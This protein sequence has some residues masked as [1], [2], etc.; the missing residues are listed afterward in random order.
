VGKLNH[1]NKPRRG[2]TNDFP[3]DDRSH[4]DSPFGSFGKTAAVFMETN[5]FRSNYIEVLMRSQK[6]LT[7]GLLLLAGL[8][9]SVPLGAQTRPVVI[10]GG[11]LIDGTGREA[12]TDAAIVL[13]DGR[14]QEVGKRGQVTLP[15][16]AEVINATGKT[17]LPGLIDGHCH[18]WEWVGELY[19][20]YGVTT[21]PDINNSPTEWILAQRD[22]IQKGKIR[23]PRLWI[24]GYALD[25]PRPEGMPEQR[26]M[27]NSIIVRSEEEA[28]QAVRAH[29]E[30]GMDGF[31]FLERLAPDVAK[32]AAN[33]ARRLGRPVI[34]H[35][36]DIFSAVDAGYTS[37]EHSW[38]VMFT[39]IRDAK[40]KAEIDMDR[41]TGKVST[42]EEHIYMEPDFFDQIIKAMVEKDVH[43]SPAWATQFR[44]L[45]PRAPEMKKRELAILKNPRLAYLPAYNLE[46]VEGYFESF[47]KLTP[48][49][50]SRLV[51]AY[52]MVQDFARRYVAAGGKIHSG[53]DPGS[54]LPAYAVHAEFELM[55]DAGFSP[56]AAIQSA[57]LNVARAWGKDRDFG[58]VEKGKVAD[59]VIVGG[60]VM[61]DISV[62]QN[63]EK[64]FM[65]GKPVDTSFHP[66]YRNPIPRPLPDRF[67]TSL[68]Q[69]SPA[70]LVEGSAGQIKL[71]GANFRPSHQ[72]LLNGKKIE[73][74]FSSGSELEARIPALAAG[75]YKVTVMDPGVAASESNAVYVVISFK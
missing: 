64:V 4:S 12:V 74:R 3:E 46:S 66:N 34:A 24:S 73:S 16:G 58:S 8:L 25:G 59:L 29:V 2:D 20:A 15:P 28:R 70:S 75:T 31:K 60:D 33:E 55:I 69:V 38:A 63:V 9:V 14:I 50:R 5:R 18:Y 7:V 10:Q 13:R 48:E 71:T 65:E 41:M 36:L 53:S 37:V 40:R 61:E 47:E 49:K 39:T 67:L 26:W 21:C 27:R 51:S 1:A 35:S 11:T 32:A 19:L 72:V 52:K 57:S 62:T 54:L 56:L 45:S 68:S 6:A 30:M 17:I 42:V 43:W 22:G 23:G 44:A